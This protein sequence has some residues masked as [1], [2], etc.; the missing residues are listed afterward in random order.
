M[1]IFNLVGNL[2]PIEDIEGVL[3]DEYTYASLFRIEGR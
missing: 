2:W 3:L 1:V